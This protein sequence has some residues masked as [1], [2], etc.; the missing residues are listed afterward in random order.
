MFFVN[1]QFRIIEKQP[2]AAADET[3]FS[4]LRLFFHFSMVSRMMEPV[5][6]VILQNA[7]KYIFF[8]IFMVPH[9]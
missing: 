7:V 2:K 4:G 1:E 6:L 8:T 5:L 3:S 9:Y